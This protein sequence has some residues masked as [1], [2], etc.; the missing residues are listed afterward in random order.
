MPE[1]KIIKRLL[2][3]TIAIILLN[4]GVT[5]YGIIRN[6]RTY[7]QTAEQLTDYAIRRESEL[8]SQLRD[9]VEHQATSLRNNWYDWQQEDL[10]RS[11][12]FAELEVARQLHGYTRQS[13]GEQ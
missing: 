11:R 9:Y 5:S 1:L 4:I 2:A 7:A 8:S 6:E 10:A 12:R 3:T 13:F